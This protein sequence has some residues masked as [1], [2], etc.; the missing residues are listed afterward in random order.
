MMKRL[1][2]LLALISLLINPLTTTSHSAIEAKRFVSLEGRFSISLP[3]RPGSRR[4]AIPIPF[5]SAHGD[6]YQ[7]STNEGTFG[8][9]YADST[10]SLDDPE[11]A[12]KFFDETT[13][14]FHK[15]AVANGGNIAVVKKI[16]LDKYPGIEQR[17]DLFTGSVIQRMYLVSRRVYETTVVIKN[18]QRE[19]EKTAMAVLDSF[20]LLSDPEITEEA[21]KAGPGPL[22]QTPEAPRAGSD[23]NDEGL[24]GR[25]KSV[26]TEIQY[27][28]ESPFTKTADRVSFTTYNE[29]GNKLITE[30]YDF[31][32]NLSTIRVFGYLDGA[33]VSAHKF[34]QRDY[35]PPVGRGG[36]GPSP[37]NRKKDPRYDQKFEFKYD[38]KNRL[39]ERTQFLSNGDVL[40]R[41]VYK[42]DGNQKEELLY[43]D[44]SSQPRRSLYILDDKGNVIED[45]DFARDDSIQS[46]TTYTYEFDSNGNWTR[47]TTTPNIQSERLRQLNPPSV[48]IRTITYF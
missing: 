8:I 24:R 21:L 23:A 11:T 30:S 41:Y 17:A 29:K 13:A 32:N 22:P 2:I 39:I 14:S 40:Y 43:L 25:V 5:G 33:R 48:H 15:L 27:V 28:T 36:D 20:K 45:T 44:N 37:S 12:K 4:L 46:K 16:T 9:G 19:H 7:W 38:D 35:S 34:I 3:D 31:R 18:S 47:R 1:A 42:Y 26:R 6:L 10:R